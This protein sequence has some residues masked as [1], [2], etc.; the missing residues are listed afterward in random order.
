MI[1]WFVD[2]MIPGTMFIVSILYKKKAGGEISAISGFRT[3][4]SMA[5]KENWKKAH[6]LAGRY[7]F[8][9][10]IALLIYILLIKTSSPMAPEYLSLVNTFI[11]L[12]ALICT[13]AYIHFKLGKNL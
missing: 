4:Y 12:S 10:S 2:L 9:I 1:F 3:K 6:L 5:S 11:S 8:R 7:S 13:T